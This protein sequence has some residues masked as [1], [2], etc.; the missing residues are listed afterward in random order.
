MDPKV[1]SDVMSMQQK[2]E[3]RKARFDQAGANKLTTQEASAVSYSTL[4]S[5]L[6]DQQVAAEAEKKK[7]DRL[8]RFGIP[9]P[10]EEE[11]KRLA[12]AKKY[13]VPTPVRPTS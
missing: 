2:L 1:K 10:D 3:W 11:A 9:D 12:R 8:K 5:I 7:K 6:T 13:G 4:L